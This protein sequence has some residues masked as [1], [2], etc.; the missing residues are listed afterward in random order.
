MRP[1]RIIIGADD[2]RATALLR[3]LYA[4]F[5]RNHER[6]HG[7][8]RALGRAHQVR[9]QRDA[10]DAHLVHERARQPG[11]GAR[12]RHRGGAPRHRLRP[13]HRLPVP[14]RRRR[15]RRLVL[16]EGREGAAAHARPRPA[17]RCAC[18]RAVEQANEAQ[19]HVLARQDQAR[20][21]ARTCKGKRFAVWGLAFKP[22]TDDM[23]EAPS[24]HADRRPA[25]RRARRCAPTIRWRATKRED[26][27]KENR[28]ADR[29]VGARPRSRAPTRWPSSPSGRS[30]AAPTSPRSRR[31]LKTPAIF[32]GRNL[33]DPAV[34]ERA[35]LRV[36]P[37]RA[38]AE[39]TRHARRR[40]CWW[41]AT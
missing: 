13:A 20:G 7:D 11:R 33:Y 31:S 38:E 12:R 41:S 8:G 32:D 29:R 15:L 28:R 9:R 35:R 17:A 3:E 14:L 40:A 16:S 2:A 24:L 36:F 10:R 19:K 22:N 5:Q 25:R 34:L 4:P 23:R 39:G 26:L 27:R 37:D 30:S 6:M 18:W 21:S 1:D